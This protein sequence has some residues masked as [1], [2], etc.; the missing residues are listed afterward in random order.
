MRINPL[1]NLLKDNREEIEKKKSH[2]QME[3]IG[4]MFD[5]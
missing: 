4:I 1:I 3:N 5:F 2:Q